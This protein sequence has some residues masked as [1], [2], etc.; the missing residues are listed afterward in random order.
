MLRFY[1][2]SVIKTV[3]TD[4]KLCL[5]CIIRWFGIHYWLDLSLFIEDMLIYCVNMSLVLSD[6]LKYT[7]QYTLYTTYAIKTAHKNA[8]IIY[9]CLI[10]TNGQEVVFICELMRF[11]LI[12]TIIM[13]SC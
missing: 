9:I 1:L 6:Y 2:Y 10:S 8:T 3:S 5:Q 13:V 11:Y 7:L 12:G 4:I